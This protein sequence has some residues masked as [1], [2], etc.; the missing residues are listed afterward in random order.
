M[1]VYWLELFQLKY[2]I[3]LGTWT[4]VSQVMS[5]CFLLPQR[6]YVTILHIMGV[7]VLLVYF[8]T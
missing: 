1:L 8:D 2:I 7:R 3:N 5:L 4:Q 6:W